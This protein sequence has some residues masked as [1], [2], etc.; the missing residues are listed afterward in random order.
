[1]RINSK[2]G[3]TVSEGKPPATSSQTVD[4]DNSAGSD[5]RSVNRNVN[6]NPAQLSGTQGWV[7]A[8]AA[9]VVQLP[10]LRQEK[11]RAL[12]QAVQS[13]DYN[14]DPEQVAGALVSHLGVNRPDAMDEAG[15]RGSQECA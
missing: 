3:R 15:G 8:L 12:R 4:A 5:G 9:E 11:V 2:Q 13:G 10:E 1:M 6:E 14:P 7:Q